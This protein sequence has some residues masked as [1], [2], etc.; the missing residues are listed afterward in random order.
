MHSQNFIGTKFDLFSLL[1]FCL[2][3]IIW[4]DDGEIKAETQSPKQRSMSTVCPRGSRS[5]LRLFSWLQKGVNIN[6]GNM[7]WMFFEFCP[8]SFYALM[9]EEFTL[10]C[11]VSV[12]CVSVSCLCVCV[13]KVMWTLAE[14]QCSHRPSTVLSGSWF[15]LAAFC[16]LTVQSHEGGV[17]VRLNFINVWKPW[18]WWYFT[19]FTKSELYF[20]T[21]HS[22][23]N[24]SHPNWQSKHI[25][26]FQHTGNPFVITLKKKSKEYV[27][28]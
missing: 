28:T 12:L 9:G 11:I 21:K 10:C 27:N 3:G 19:L 26:Y 16:W 23:G 2:I 5:I 22:Q 6:Q 24:S 7:V 4:N 25:F 8:C 17:S 1:F 18:S 14:Q 15:A 13:L 20:H